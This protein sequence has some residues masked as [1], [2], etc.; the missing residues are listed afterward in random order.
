MGRA[1]K[2]A[3]DFQQPAI[4]IDKDENAVV[5]VDIVETDEFHQ[6]ALLQVSH[7]FYDEIFL[8]WLDAKFLYSP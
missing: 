3:S 4:R 7:I 1:R 5:I 6:L 8:T 2:V